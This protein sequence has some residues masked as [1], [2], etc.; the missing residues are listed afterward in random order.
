MQ[1]RVKLFATLRHGRGKE[2]LMELKE[3]TTTE[4]IIKQLEIEEADIAI[5]LINGRDG[6]LSNHYTTLKRRMEKLEGS[7]ITRH[8]RS[9][10][11]E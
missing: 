8:C 3:N 10:L 6:L 2:Q 7:K 9:E 11:Q 1:V 5:L 4:Y